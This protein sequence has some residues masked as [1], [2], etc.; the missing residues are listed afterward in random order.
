M[1]DLAKTGVDVL[2][3]DADA[4]LLRDP[5]PYI[6]NL[7]TADVL[8]SSDHLTSTKGYEDAGLEDESGF[9][10]AFN[11]GYIYIKAAATE[12]VQALLP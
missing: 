4:F 1:L 2:T 6:R 9:H 5:F 11:I 3:V 8:T 12:F 7:P 10:S